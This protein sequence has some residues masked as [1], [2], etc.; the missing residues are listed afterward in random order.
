[1]KENDKA[2]KA[3]TGRPSCLRAP[4]AHRITAA[5]LLLCLALICFG[6]L[7]SYGFW[8]PW[9]PLYVQ[10]AREM[11]A[12]G[13]W[14]VPTYRGNPRYSKPILVYWGVKVSRAILG[15][16]DWAARLP[17]TLTAFAALLIAWRA[18]SG[19]RG[20]TTGMLA[21]VVL[22]TTPFYA[23]FAR[24][25]TPDTYLL[26]GITIAAAA[27]TRAHF[28]PDP[29]RRWY[30]LAYLGIGI[31]VLGKG[32]AGLILPAMAVGFYV[33]YTLDYERIKAQGAIS[34]LV[35]IT[36]LLGLSVMFLGTAAYT[37]WSGRMTS[38][39]P[40]Q[41][42]FAQFAQWLKGHHLYVAALVVLGLASA[43]SAAWAARMLYRFLVKANNADMKEAALQLI[44]EAALCLLVVVIL[45]GPWYLA[46][47]IKAGQDYVDSFIIHRHLD[48]LASKVR[49]AGKIDLY[50][51]AV[52][53]G[54][55]PWFALLPAAFAGAFGAARARGS[56][57]RDEKLKP[58]IFLAGWGLTTALLFMMAVTQFY[59]YILPA[60]PPLA[61]LLALRLGRWM[62]GKE[63]GRAKAFVVI[64]ILLLMPTMRDLLT[65]RLR[66]FLRLISPHHYIS[67]DLQRG[68]LIWCYLCFAFFLAGLGLFLVSRF[69]REGIALACAAMV[70]FSLAMTNKFMVDVG[71]FKS[72][73]ALT[74]KYKELSGYET[75]Y[76]F[77]P[78][79]PHLVYYARDKAVFFEDHVSALIREMRRRPSLYLMATEEQ[80][81]KIR[82]RLDRYGLSLAVMDETSHYRYRIVYIEVKF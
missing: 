75:V 76:S 36:V 50:F 79:S 54:F 65:V 42:G 74:A 17:S 41:G 60:I 56:L 43:A 1:M 6:R 69:R 11:E 35:L 44:R 51:K 58:E 38:E 18:L 19:L 9:E 62:E 30:L 12:S 24:R 33:V 46:V 81:R 25:A 27:L 34:G 26:A 31:A 59:H 77:G 52:M 7:G 14:I 40:L 45:A 39:V 16:A 78:Q 55:F 61:L 32:P 66:H 4:W 47:T 53:F 82:A 63:S 57:R 5:F 2:V 20:D 21:A 73:R 37:A 22:A 67:K 15:E 8:D 13:H 49:H 71:R 72:P 70:I 48:S 28:G 64:G 29:K 23:L 68:M 10:G 3:G 80:I